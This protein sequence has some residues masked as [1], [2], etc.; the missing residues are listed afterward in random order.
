M[1]KHQPAESH[2]ATATYVNRRYG[3]WIAEFRYRRYTRNALLVV[4]ETLGQPGVF[5]VSSALGCWSAH[6]ASMLRARADMKGDFATQPQGILTEGPYAGPFAA[7]G[8]IHFDGA[9]RFSGVA[10]S[11][12]NGG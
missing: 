3:E 4:L 11:S 9:G 12:F 8:V 10:T 7:T 5:K 2:R 1:S 6:R